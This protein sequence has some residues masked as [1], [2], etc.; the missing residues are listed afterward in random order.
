[1]ENV[2]VDSDGFLDE[3]SSD[4]EWDIRERLR[5][6]HKAF[7]REEGQPASASSDAVPQQTQSPRQRI[8]M[9]FQVMQVLQDLGLK[10]LS[11]HENEGPTGPPTDGA[12]TSS[13]TLI[14]RETGYEPP[15]PPTDDPV[16]L[17]IYRNDAL[18]RAQEAQ[19]LDETI[20]RMEEEHRAFGEAIEQSIR[21]SAEAK[22]KAEP[23][24]VLFSQL[25]LQRAEQVVQNYITEA[26]ERL[27]I[28]II[29]NGISAVNLLAR[30]PMGDVDSARPNAKVRIRRTTRKQ[31]R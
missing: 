31:Q 12:G 9:L 8:G 27:A 24:P 28:L 21:R 19:T 20:A 29:L 16:L 17:Q 3:G 10:I 30:V 22:A 13:T 11:L 2:T 7:R 25:P 15:F 23:A 1:M 5:R 14:E 18:T 6:D 26:L 4:V